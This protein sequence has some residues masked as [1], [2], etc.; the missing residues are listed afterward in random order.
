MSTTSFLRAAAGTVV[1]GA[2][3]AAAYDL[4][5]RVVKNVSLRESAVVATSWAIRG[6]RVAEAGAENARLAVADVVAEAKERV[7]EETTPPGV[8]GGHDHDH[9]H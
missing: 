6:T 8:G 2:V 3:G 5:K 4:T 9:D 1:T 7:G